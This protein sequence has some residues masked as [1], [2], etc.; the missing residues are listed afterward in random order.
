LIESDVEI[1]SN[2]SIDRG[3][4]ADTI[5]R[6]GA[7]IDNQTHIS[8]NVVIGRATAVIA[9]SMVGGSVVIG[10]YGWVA[11][12]ACIM[13][14]RKLG[15]RVTVGLQALVVKDVP[16]GTTVMGSPA[17]TQE[18]FQRERRKL[19]ALATASDEGGGK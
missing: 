8:H 2:T 13:N 17:I 18:E 14:Q 7:K 4:L 9:Q 15:S 1:G 5:I 12:S 16:D 19:K 6:S 3:A 10:D 11:P